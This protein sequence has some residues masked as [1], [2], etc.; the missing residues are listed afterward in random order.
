MVLR[1]RRNLGIVTSFDG[2]GPAQS[3]PTPPDHDPARLAPPA[4]PWLTE[5]PTSVLGDAASLRG[6]GEAP[7]ADTAPFAGLEAGPPRRRV[8]PWIVA[9]LA[10]CALCVAGLLII[11][12]FGSGDG[13]GAQGP[14][15]TAVP[16]RTGSG[17]DRTPTTKITT[18][19]QPDG[20]A[21][22][23]APGTSANAGA[24]EVVYEVTASGSRNTGSVTYSDQDGDFIRLH[25]I[26]LPWRVSF[27]VGGQR[28]PL[29]LLAQRK[30]GGDA[31]PVTCTITVGGKLLS[32]TTAEGKYASAQCS[33]SG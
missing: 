33:G 5:S 4:D 30:G 15:P 18:G 20:S 31:G 8:Y 29:V 25:G 7:P 28:K 12:P 9:V 2:D 23:A 26:P 19:R 6:H 1:T 13:D 32:S 11:D 16:T 27:P 10:A 3:D 14:D 21:G 17:P 22:A 24:P